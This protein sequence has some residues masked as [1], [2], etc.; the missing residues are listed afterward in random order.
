MV[1]IS[2]I[3]HNTY[4]YLYNCTNLS[5]FYLLEGVDRGSETQL[6]VVEKNKLYNLAI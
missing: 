4:L 2:I 6:K 3:Q 5:M 1:I